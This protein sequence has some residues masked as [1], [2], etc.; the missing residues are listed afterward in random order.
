VEAVSA[1]DVR[2]DL[3]E[4]RFVIDDETVGRVDDRRGSAQ[5]S[6]A[7]VAGT[8]FKSTLSERASA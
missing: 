1:H 3:T 4:A 5:G 7:A 6:F 8:I 2:Q